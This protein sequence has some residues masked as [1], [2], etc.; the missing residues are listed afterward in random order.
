MT[1]VDGLCLKTPNSNGTHLDLS[2]D[3]VT[4]DHEMSVGDSKVGLETTSSEMVWLVP[5]HSQQ[6]ITK[7]VPRQLHIS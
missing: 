4:T 3:S 5:A 6:E 2:L 7:E 1:L